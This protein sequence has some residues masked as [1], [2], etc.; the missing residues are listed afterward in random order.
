MKVTSND[1]D[2][3]KEDQVKI[4]QFSRFNMQYHDKLKLI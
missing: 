4:N 3:T 1:I 2:V